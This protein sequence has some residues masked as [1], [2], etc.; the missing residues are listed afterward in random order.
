MKKKPAPG[1]G[2]GLVG[3]KKNGRSGHI[4][5]PAQQAQAD[6]CNHIPP[7]TWS[8]DL[9]DTLMDRIAMHVRRHA[10]EQFGCMTLDQ[11]DLI[12]SELRGEVRRLVSSH[13]DE[14]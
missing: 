3:G 8:G 11:I 4:D 10:P 7:L 1:E 14:D 2:A 9:A 13:I 6:Y 12:F 5:R